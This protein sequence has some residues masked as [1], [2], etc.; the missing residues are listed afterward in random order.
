M[1]IGPG[2]HLIYPNFELCGNLWQLLIYPI[3]ID[4]KI[5]DDGIVAVRLVNMSNESVRAAY[6]ITIK[7]RIRGKDDLVFSDPEGIVLFEPNGKNDQWGTDDLISTVELMDPI[8]GLYLEDK[9]IIN[10]ELELFQDIAIDLSPLSKA[11]NGAEDS[12]DLIKLA[13][14]DLKH[15]LKKLPVQ[16]SSEESVMKQ[17]D[18]LLKHMLST[19]DNDSK[20]LNR[21]SRL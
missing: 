13:K 15:I 10:L 9:I 17:Q 3:G 7:S 5:S 12:K 6:C 2:K 21:R 19:N 4:P 20:T 11:I 18:V 14:N 16:K 8:L 1:Y